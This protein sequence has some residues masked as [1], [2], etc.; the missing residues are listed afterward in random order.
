MRFCGGA[1]MGQQFWNGFRN[2]G[3]TQSPVGM[4]NGK[5]NLDATGIRVSLCEIV[6]LSHPKEDRLESPHFNNL[7]Q[8]VAQEK[9]YNNELKIAK[10][11]FEKFA[12]AIFETDRSYDAR[13]NSFHNWYILDRP[14]QGRRKTPL[15]YFLEFNAN[16][17]SKKELINYQELKDNI[18]SLFELVKIPR[19]KT[20]VRDL[21]TGKKY[22]IADSAQT[23]YMDKG[24]LF[25]SRIFRHDGAYYFSNYFLLHPAAVWKQV[26]KQ[27]RRVRKAKEDSTPFLFLLVLFQ[28]RFDQYKQMEPAK[29]YRFDT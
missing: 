24:A 10:E 3:A 23:D 20:L 2:L 18:H 27:A 21:A 9:R 1:L 14:L 22:E 28:S 7:L 17:L 6:P 13:I 8:F 12:G 15:E 4:L 19:G 29:I 16:S 11:E 26:K 5:L 25:N